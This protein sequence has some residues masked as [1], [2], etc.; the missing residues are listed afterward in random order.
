MLFSSP[1]LRG[2]L[3]KRYKRFLADVE[4]E[5]GS[6]VVAHCPNTG[7]MTGCAEPGFTVYLSHSDNPK[8]KLRYTWELAEDFQHNFIGINTHNANKLVAEALNNKVAPYFNWVDSW[9]AEVTPPG[10]QSRFD[11]KLML[12][13]KPCFMEVKSVTL[14]EGNVGY[15]PDARTQ[16]GTKHCLEL[17]K[18]A[19]QGERCRLLFCV[20]HTG[21][22]E[23][24]LAQNI[25]SEYAD[26]VGYAQA[27]G[28]EVLAAGCTIN[29]QKI[30]INQ[31]LAVK[32]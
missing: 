5:D 6:V 15:F 25:D 31:A 21:I 29:Q 22:K 24:R 19:Q 10:A 12:E 30:Q 2:T 11:F 8:R 26:A 32:L 14:A 7:A 20:Q 17:A 9:K 23:V 28:V 1:L 27:H 13:G 4:L 18:L 3:I 16:R